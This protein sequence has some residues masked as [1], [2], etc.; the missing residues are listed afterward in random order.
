MPKL[1][2]YNGKVDSIENIKVSPMSRAFLFSDSVYEVISFYKNEFID[3]ETHLDRLKHSLNET[4]ISCSIED[5]KT[6]IEKLLSESKSEDGYIYFQVSRGVDSK[7]SHFFEDS[8]CE[9]FG[10]VEEFSF[11]NQLPLRVM[12]VDDIR[13][14]R[15][16]I[17]STSL[18]GNVL[19]MNDAKSIGCNEIL[20]HKNGELTE[21]GASNIFFVKDKTIFTPELSS[22][23]L[24][25]ITRHQ[26]IEIIKDEKLDFQEGSYGI[27]D[28]NEASSIWFTSTTKGI[29]GVEEIVN[30]ETK[31]NPECELLEI[32]KDAFVK[33]YFS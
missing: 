28:L 16:D 25:G 32:C 22:N 29:V 17:K 9:R 19:Q 33:K 21:G 1:A 8:D 14:Q 6:E 30:L 31:I 2:S 20:M 27:N 26:V 7:R 24:P 23:I 10:F 13:W 12:L 5:C 15:C 11:F 3:F 4:K 18:L